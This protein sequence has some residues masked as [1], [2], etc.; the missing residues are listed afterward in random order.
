MTEWARVWNAEL[1]EHEHEH[2]QEGQAT[3][4]SSSRSM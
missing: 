2:E 3:L 4:G 1:M